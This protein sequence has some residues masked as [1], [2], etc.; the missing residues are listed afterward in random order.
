M[1]HGTGPRHRPPVRPSHLLTLGRRSATFTTGRQPTRAAAVP[2]LEEPDEA[3]FPR[4]RG[5]RAAAVTAGIASIAL[6]AS[7]SVA[8]SESEGGGE[9]GTGDTLRVVLTQEPPTLEACDANLTSTG[10]VVRSTVTEPLVER[11]PSTGELEP[12][13]ATEWEQTG[14]TEWTFTVRDDVTFQDG[15]PFDAEAAAY[16]IDRAV[17]GDLGCNVEGYIFGDDDLEVEA[18]D[19]TTLTVTTPSP[20]PILPLK[21]SFIEIVSPETS[22]TEFVREPVGTGPYAIGE[23]QAG[24]KLTLER[25]DDYWGDAPQ[26]ADV[27][28]QWR[29]EGTVRA[30]MITSGE[31]DIALGLSAE[32]G[33]GDLGV[34]YPNNE[35]IAL[36]FSGETA[37]LDDIRIRQAI[38]YAIDREGIVSSLY[39]DGDKV[40]AQLIPEGIVGF[41][42]DLEPW[43]Y[44]PEK[45]K[46]LVEEAA[47]DGVA[48]DTKILM[49]VRTAQFP[50]V[51]ELGEV[52]REQLAAA[53]L[54]VELRMVDTTQ[55]LQY[56]LSPFVT[57]E[58]PISMLIQHGN[59]AGDA[60][61]TVEQY[62]LTGGAQAEF[63]D[64]ALDELI[65]TARTL[66]GDERQAA[67]EEVFAYERENVVA[68]APIAHQTVMLGLADRVTYEPNS[69]TGDELRI[70]EVSLAG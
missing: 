22:N 24:T 52:L 11:N 12:L 56:Q 51:S 40:A 44:D 31:A 23:W 14:D 29:S 7:C 61:F 18:T 64:P 3:F 1:P 59:Q 50:K 58:G 68:L 2:Y 27:E 16:S 4:R 53:G 47:A 54:N 19:A 46:A 43:E 62:M 55:H 26:F 45:A 20:D 49:P 65:T 69:S 8:N 35:T 25:N 66:T 28:Y 6:L 41:N 63:G 48:V 9:G 30:A 10:V 60:Q 5:T 39:P 13:L 70:K 67:Y 37:P 21:L 42:A 38:N 17:N 32:D 57:N 33:I 36:R 34:S 15:T